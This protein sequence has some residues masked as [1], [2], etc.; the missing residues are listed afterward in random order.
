MADTKNIDQLTHSRIFRAW[1][2][3]IDQHTEMV[4]KCATEGGP[5]ISIFRFLREVKKREYN[6]EFYHAELGGSVWDE[7][8]N[9]SNS[10]KQIQIQYDP[11]KTVAICVQIPLGE[12]GEETVGEIKLFDNENFE[13]LNI[14]K[15]TDEEKKKEEEYVPRESES[16]GIRRRK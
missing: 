5:G 6:C 4:K 7:L 15:K 12:E 13:E 8:L 2:C 10:K 14:E 11:A 3:I 9:L 1:D 16:S